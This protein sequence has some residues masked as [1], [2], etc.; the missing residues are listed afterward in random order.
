MPTIDNQRLSYLTKNEAKEVLEILKFLDTT[1]YHLTVILLF[2][3]ARL[4]EIT[5]AESQKTKSGKSTSLKWHDVNF[6]NNRIFLKKT[7]NG[8]ARYVAMNGLLKETMLYLY[9]HRINDSVITTN[10][11]GVI[12]KMPDHFATAVE[13]VIPGNKNRETKYK[14]TAHSLRHTHASWLAE[15]GLDIF[16]IKEQLGH[17]TIDMTMRYSHLVESKRHELTV[18]LKL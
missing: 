15:N 10:T 5:G 6:N 1:T 11:G 12:L 8:N 18:D 13:A 7:K 14:I 3:G 2:T 9:E 4:S 17:K 16:Q